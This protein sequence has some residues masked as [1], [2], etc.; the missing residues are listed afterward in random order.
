MKRKVYIKSEFET[1]YLVN[2]VFGESI[3]PFETD[4]DSVFYI[5]LLPLKAALLPY[6]VKITGGIPQNNRDLAIVYSL[7][8]GINEITFKPR[9]NYV[10]SPQGVALRNTSKDYG[11]NTAARCF[12]LIKSGDFNEA[13]KYMSG[14]LKSLKDEELKKYFEGYVDAMH[15]SYYGD[16]KN[17]LILV[18]NNGCGHLFDIA[19][20]DGL[21]DNFSLIEF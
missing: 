17:S 14:S 18:D 3:P 8:K 2:G 6:T 5:T 16:Y 7:P 20:T 11:Q 21:I 1:A 4:P 9:L 15:N 19:F 10:Y 12:F 13:R